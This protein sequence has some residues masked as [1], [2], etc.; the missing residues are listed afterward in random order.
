LD[1]IAPSNGAGFTN[2]ADGHDCGETDETDAEITS[3]RAQSEHWIDLGS[4]TS[5]DVACGQS[6]QEKQDCDDAEGER[7][8]RFGGEEERRDPLG[9]D[10]GG[11]SSEADSG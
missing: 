7:V 6:D 2:R 11:D 9:D 5:R 8:S 3:V 4:A 1:R 10:E